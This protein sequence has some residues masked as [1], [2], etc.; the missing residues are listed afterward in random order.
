MKTSKWIWF[1]WL[2]V[3]LCYAVPY[4]FLSDVQAWYG[5]FLFWSLTGLLIIGANIFMTKDFEEY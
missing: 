4:G 5:S 3:V 1:V 2:L